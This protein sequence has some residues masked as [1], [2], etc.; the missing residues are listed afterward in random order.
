MLYVYYEANII[1]MYTL[2]SV[3]TH[4][5]DQT[6]IALHFMMYTIQ[7]V[8][9]MQCDWT[10]IVYTCECTAMIIMVEQYICIGYAT[11]LHLV[12]GVVVF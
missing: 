5:V 2:H 12:Q 3:A 9:Y 4:Y 8:W 11:G 1:I 7:S 10:C 6:M